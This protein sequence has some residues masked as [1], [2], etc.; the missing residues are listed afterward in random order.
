MLWIMTRHNLPSLL[1]LHQVYSVDLLLAIK[2]EVCS[3][4]EIANLFLTPPSANHEIKQP[5]LPLLGFKQH[6]MPPMVS[7]STF[8]N[9]PTQLFNGLEDEQNKHIQKYAEQTHPK[10]CKCMYFGSIWKK[11]EIRRCVLKFWRREAI[12][13]VNRSG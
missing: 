7:M 4:I 9:I 10:V 5:R 6:L 12:D 8:L 3:I 1:D 13:D 2:G 11:T